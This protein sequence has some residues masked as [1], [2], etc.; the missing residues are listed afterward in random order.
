[1]LGAAAL[2]R[3]P[4]LHEARPLDGAADEGRTTRGGA[5][6]GCRRRAGEAVDRLFPGEQRLVGVARRRR[7]RDAEL[8]LGRRGPAPGDAQG[9]RALAAPVVEPHEEPAGR[10]VQRILVQQA[11]GGRDRLGESTAL[12]ERLRET[13]EGLRVE[14]AQSLA[15]RVGPLVVAAREEI[16][17]VE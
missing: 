13:L 6:R 17:A 10:L 15:R 11:L 1:E 14:P 7:G 8:A 3:T 4:A 12:L 16:A 9:T 2:A 5:R